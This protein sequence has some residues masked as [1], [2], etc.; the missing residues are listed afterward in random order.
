MYKSHKNAPISLLFGILGVS[1]S[2][3]L[4]LLKVAVVNWLI[5]VHA[6]KGNT[7]SD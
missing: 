7:K 4:P 3:I 5:S 2:T 1:R 6:P